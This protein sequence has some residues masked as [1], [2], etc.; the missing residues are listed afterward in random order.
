MIFLLM[1]M[2]IYVNSCGR[3]VDV[4]PGPCWY[5]LVVLIGYCTGYAGI[6]ETGAM[7]NLIA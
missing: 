6:K 5:D 2:L 3:I 1:G 7:V 4:F